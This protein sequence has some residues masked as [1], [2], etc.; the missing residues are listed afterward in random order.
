MVKRIILEE[1]FK[2]YLRLETALACELWSYGGYIGTVDFGTT[3]HSFK[4]V[5]KI[6]ETRGKKSYGR[7]TISIYNISLYSGC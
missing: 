4:S 3:S 6:R 1:I 2:E 5:L 7:V